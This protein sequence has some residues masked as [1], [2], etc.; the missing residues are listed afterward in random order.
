[1]A[2]DVMGMINQ[3]IAAASGWFVRVLNSTGIVEIYFAFIFIS[4]AI[5]FIMKPL[6]GGAKSDIARVSKNRKGS[7][8]DDYRSKK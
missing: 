5:G 8:Y 4:L 3:S 2:A 1:M 6:L 7:S